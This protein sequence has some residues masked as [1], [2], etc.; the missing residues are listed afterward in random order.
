MS[1]DD[2]FA[3]RRQGRLCVRNDESIEG[4]LMKQRFALLIV[5]ACM[6]GAAVADD[7]MWLYNAPPN[8]QLKSKYGFNATQQWLD[9]VRLG[10]VRV[11]N[12]GSGSF[13]SPTGL[14]FTNHHV[15]RGC[16]QDLS[17]KE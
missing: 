16:M 15:G 11:N 7:G 5:I 8:K 3:G 4:L 14:T 6:L 12:G 13:V 10:S 17:T 1:Y 2:W 9:H